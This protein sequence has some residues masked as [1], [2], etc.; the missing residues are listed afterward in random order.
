[1]FVCA[2]WILPVVAVAALICGCTSSPVERSSATE[3]KQPPYGVGV[4]I[5]KTYD[6]VLLTHCGIV[7]AQIDGSVWVA[8]PLLG[9]PTNPPEG[10]DN[11]TAEGTLRLLSKD[12]AEFVDG[13][14]R[15]VFV[16]ADA[17]PQLCD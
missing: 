9:T 14:N 15:A 4:Q 6:Y 5:G 8:D 16:R 1:M 17:A 13:V 10:W 3:Q 12:R 2:K 7:Q 11:P